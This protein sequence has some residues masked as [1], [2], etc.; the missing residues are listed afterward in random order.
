HI[1]MLGSA[2]IARRV[3]EF[4]EK[5]T[6]P[7]VVLDPIM[8]SSSGTDLLDPA[9]IAVLTQRLFA[10]AN[11]VTP[12]AHEAAALIGAEV[13]TVD[14]MKLAAQRLHEMGAKSVVITG[15]HLEKA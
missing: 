4:L 10:L 8:K 12:N 2:K 3:A 1:G 11:V 13:S 14:D 7:N 5:A 9:G 6:L 15:G